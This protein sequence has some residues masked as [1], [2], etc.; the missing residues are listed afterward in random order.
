MSCIILSYRIFGYSD[1]G[2][3]NSDLFFIF[4]ICI[5]DW[6]YNVVQICIFI[7]VSHSKYPQQKILHSDIYEIKSKYKF[8]K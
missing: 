6:F 8:E 4:L 5:V 3:D 7:T 2:S 1:I